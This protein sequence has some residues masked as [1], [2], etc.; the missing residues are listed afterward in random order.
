MRECDMSSSGAPRAR[1]RGVL[2]RLITITT[3]SFAGLYLFLFFT[4]NES[5]I[6]IFMANVFA[7]AFLVL[8]LGLT[9][10]AELLNVIRK[11][12]SALQ[13]RIVRGALI[14]SFL[15]PTVVGE[16][17]SHPRR[18]I[19]GIISGS[20][21]T[22]LDANLLGPVELDPDFYDQVARRGP[23]IITLQELNP[24]VAERL[25]ARLGDGYP[26]KVLDPKPAVFGMGVFSRY[27]CSK[28]DSTKFPPAIGIPQIVDIQ[29]PNNKT[30]GV[31]NVH[32]IPPHTFIKRSR[33]DSDLR[34]LSHAIL[35]RE[36]FVEEMIT[37]SRAVSTDA[38]I[39]T[40]D[41]NATTR[42]R[43]YSLV[44]RMRLFDS[45][46]S[47]SR[48]RGG[49]WPGPQFPLPS[50]MVRIDFIFHCAGLTSLST[51]TL[52]SGYGSDHRGLIATLAFIQPH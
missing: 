36:R 24:T 21:F 15:V 4:N 17:R 16:V 6:F 48:M 38:I 44:R 46:S 8:T 29:L 42:N 25:S 28:R 22:V 10:L 52:P 23:D 40:G 27:P 37:I 19:S 26:C 31:I 12:R 30:V 18:E 34:Q 49:T 20:V 7:P 5:N 1:L 35:E 45:F 13:H 51:E 14:V 41:F 43:V 2:A 9:L 32:T 39:L 47:G 50:W 3:T 11:R 33:N